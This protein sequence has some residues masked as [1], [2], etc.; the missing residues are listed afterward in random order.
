MSALITATDAAH[1]AT[2]V[3]V[4]NAE[5][6]DIGMYTMESDGTLKPGAR[7]AAGENGLMSTRAV[8]WAIS[9]V[10]SAAAKR[11]GWPVR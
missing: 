3:Y 2:Y 6:G 1:A 9:P 5:D 7:V 4:S 10:A 8:S 11:F